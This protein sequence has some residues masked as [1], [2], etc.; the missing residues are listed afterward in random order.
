MKH[1][2]ILTYNVC[3]MG[4]G[5][6]FVLRRAKHLKNKG[7]DV[8]IVVSFHTDYFPLKE[9]FDDYHLYIIPE[10]GDASIKYTKKEVDSII[11]SL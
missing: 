2:L 11:C 7:Y 10:M 5:Q 4:G 8:H 9:Q 6:L 1:Y 3:N